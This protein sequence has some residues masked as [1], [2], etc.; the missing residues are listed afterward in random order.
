MDREFDKFFE[1]SDNETAIRVG[2][3]SGPKNKTIEYNAISVS[4]P[5][6]T[7]EIF[8]YF[9]GGLLGNLVLT[10]NVVYTDAT[11]DNISTVEFT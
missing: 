2:I 7:T 10:V 11:K 8:S 6:S 3:I 5:N 4:Y 9:Q 1:T